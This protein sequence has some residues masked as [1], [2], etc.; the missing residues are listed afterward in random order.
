M[1]IRHF[2]TGAS[3]LALTVSAQAAAAQAVQGSSTDEQVSAPGTVDAASAPQSNAQPDATA[4]AEQ[5]GI[6]DIVV[7][8]QRREQNLQ[9]VPLAIT[10]IS[11]E[12]LQTRGVV[13]LSRL[14]EF[15]PGFSFGQTGSDVRPAMRGV[16]TANNGVTGD[17]TIGYFIDGIYQSRT[18]Q[19]A[20]GFADVATLEVQRGPQ[21][22]LYG[23]N[24]FGG[25][26]VVTT[27]APTHE[28]DY[29][30]TLTV[31]NY[32]KARFE[33]YINVPLTENVA[34]RITAVTDYAD[35]WVR[36]SY[37]RSAD[38]FDENKQYIR[39][40][41]KWD[42]GD[43]T[44]TFR[45]DYAKQGGNGASAFGYKQIGSYIDPATCQILFNSPNYIYLNE[46]AGNRDGVADC[47]TTV[48]SPTGPAGTGVDL[49][50][51]IDNQGDEFT[52]SNDYKPFRNL[53][54]ASTSLTV[55]YDFGPIALKSI[56]GYVHYRGRRTTDSDFSSSSIA[57]DQARTEADTF[58]QEVQLLSSKTGKLE[59]VVG[60]FFL[61]DN[62]V[63]GFINQ[64]LP[65]T[66][67]SS[68]L[69]APITGSQNNGTYQFERVKVYSRAAYGQ[70]TYHLTDAWS[71]TG[72]VRYTHEKKT[73]LNATAFWYLPATL[74]SGANPLTLVTINDPLPGR[75]VFPN[76]PSNCGE[77]GVTAATIL[78][79]LGQ[80]VASNYCPL[81]F[82]QTTWKAGTEYQVT[83][84]NLVYASAST[85]FRSGGFNAGLAAAQS[86]PTFDPEKVTAYEVGSKNRFFDNTVQLNL[87]AFYNR[88]SDL[89]ES[90]QIIVGGTTLQT[91]FNAA[92]ARSYGLET[93]AIW[94]P[95]PEL[96]IG[97][98]LSLLNAK[99]SNFEGVPLP[100]GGSILVS[101]ASVTAPTVV[102]GVTI[103]GVGQR[104]VIAPGYDC[105]PQAGTGGTGQPALSFVCDLSGNNIPHSPKYSGS[106]YA[107][108]KFALG[109]DSSLTP[110]VAVSFAGHHDEQ[111]FND[112]LAR[113]EP[114][115]KLDATLTYE[116]NKQLSLIGFVDNITNTKI[117]TLVSYGGTPLQA[118]YEP[119]RM[120][121]LRLQFRR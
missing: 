89:Q 60:G 2:I 86:A 49:G 62:L 32:K 22:T 78:N 61:N 63:N 74:A 94:E 58:S 70:A 92:K 116:V 80:Q 38:L 90:R 17:P 57:I 59:Y 95:T 51:P 77:N 45:A 6:G 25:N 87:S 27:N 30:S 52:V 65:R 43:F 39:G 56:T 79:S 19:A 67:R 114:W 29:G 84:R 46:R 12:T 4:A 18:S 69:A 5:D 103:A 28:L 73:Y 47:R 111:S 7:T 97:G 36:N 23:R 68:A 44:A 107:S 85:G 109:G 75:S 16:R 101:D 113:E 66:I 9:A 35:G 37:N 99:Y 106:A 64:Q 76:R 88:Y 108:Y 82:S 121:G 105:A 34:A 91:T 83:D 40:A 100:F 53:Q 24:T 118:S 13:D 1:S 96:T 33:G 81:T 115:A 26:I 102:N 54:Q 48:A 71:V 41:V 8:A 3:V 20:L 98:N 112:S 72:G 14:N 50:I 110:F 42:V 10:A 21:G 31:G 117:Q 15:V 93:E 55:S 11:G 120:Y 119:P 104:R